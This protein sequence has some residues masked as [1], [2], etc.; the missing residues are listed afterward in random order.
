MADH[1]LFS[2][3]LPELNVS[4][5]P[6]PIQEAVVELEAIFDR[7]RVHE[8]KPYV[9]AGV[10]MSVDTPTQG[11]V[12]GVDIRDIEP[13]AFL[14]HKT[15]YPYEAPRVWSD[16]PD[17]PTERLP[18]QS[19]FTSG[20]P[21]L[22]CLH[23]GSLDDWFAEH[24]LYELVVRV[25]GWLRDAA[26]DRLIRPEDG[27]EPTLILPEREEGLAVYDPEQMACVVDQQW[28]YRSNK[29]G[30]THLSCQF[31]N[32]ADKAPSVLVGL[33]PL[34]RQAIKQEQVEVELRSKNQHSGSLALLVWPQYGRE[35]DEHFGKLPATLDSLFDLAERLDLP[36]KRAI[37]QHLN[38][39]QRGTLIPVPFI[40]AVLAIPRPQNMIGSNSSIEFLNF[41]LPTTDERITSTR[42]LKPDTPVFV[43]GNRLPINADMASRLSR[44]ESGSCSQTL[45]VGCGALGSKLGLH[46]ARAGL[47]NLTLVDNDTLSPHNLIRHGLL[48]SG[49]GKN[50]AEGL[51]HEIQAMFRDEASPVH[52]QT[53]RQNVIDV[54]FGEQQLLQ[55]MDWLLDCTTSSIVLDALLDP[56]LPQIPPVMRSAIAH[57]GALGVL[58]VEGAERN[59]RVD[60]LQVCLYDLAIDD[61]SVA[62]WLQTHQRLADEAG[63][64][65]EEITI[66]LGCSS[67][68][69]RMADDTISYHA[70]AASITVKSVMNDH[71]FTGVQISRLNS[72]GDVLGSVD[73]VEVGKFEELLPFGNSGW[74]VRVRGSVRGE[75]IAQMKQA[76]PNEA[77]GILVG[78]IHHKR[79]IIYVTRALPPPPDSEGWPYAFRLG[80]EDV[81]KELA[82]I[83]T[84][85]GG[86]IHYVGEWHSH[87]NGSS[88]LS[89]QDVDTAG[90]L[91]SYLHRAGLPTHIMI[92]TQAGCFPHIVEGQI[93]RQGGDESGTEYGTRLP[94]RRSAPSQP[95]SQSAQRALRQ[96]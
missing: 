22:L 56:R 10:T 85:T 12:K 43:L 81:P 6:R 38:W 50:K 14:F 19:S 1:Y 83:T 47:A 26:S 75:L 39:R 55:E 24:T 48:T 51:A 92:V 53:R 65:L 82:E 18:H 31:L 33:T 58:L 68:T 88:Q 59:P 61:D 80:V 36:L 45:L 5:C 46:L 57:D 96:A 3:T 7:V 86:V 27:F 73:Q 11:P 54:L 37:Y 25:Q 67:P 44:T 90:Q 74:I 17:F 4:H 9:V 89:S 41:A 40:T 23:R 69:M 72:R 20:Q 64:A 15:R 42:Q 93:Q 77:G 60:D 79:R 16:R 95:G 2:E 66:G 8:W 32:A 84:R 35:T 52:V 70:A 91:T 76:L 87:P 21:P 62:E 78:H 28:K 29:S 34:P 63:S 13:I 30:S 94:S 49:V 71:T